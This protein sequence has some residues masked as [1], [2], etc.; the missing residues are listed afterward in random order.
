M[1][2][3]IKKY[4]YFYF[5][6]L[7]LFFISGCNQKVNNVVPI[8]EYTNIFGGKYHINLIISEKNVIVNIDNTEN[9]TYNLWVNYRYSCATK[10]GNFR[11][12]VYYGNK[13]FNAIV[14]EIP[15][16]NKICDRVLSLI[17]YDVNGNVIYRSQPINLTGEKNK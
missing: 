13:R 16:K 12:R 2:I 17:M 5:I 6:I 14:V 10:K 11:E 15:N 3:N 9:D 4:K 1:T 7:L 8:G